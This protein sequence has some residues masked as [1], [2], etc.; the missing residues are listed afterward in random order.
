MTKKIRTQS[1]KK[2]IRK[3][4]YELFVCFSSF[5][6]RCLAI[7]SQICKESFKKVIVIHNRYG[8]DEVKENNE[9]LKKMFDSNCVEIGVDLKNPLEFADLFSQELAKGMGRT[10]Y[11]ALIDITTFNHEFLMICMHLLSIRRNI[12]DICCLYSSAEEYCPQSDLQEKWLSK[13]CKEIRPVLGYSGMLLPSQKNRLIIIVGYEY[14]R[15]LDVINM[16]E[17]NAITLIYGEAQKATTEK[18]KE[19]NKYYMSTVK[20]LSY[21]YSDE[22]IETLSIPC[23]DPDKAAIILEKLYEEYQDENVI[24]IPMNNKLSTLAVV[25]SLD[26][27]EDVQVCYAP[28][29]VYNELNY[30]TPGNTCYI[31]DFKKKRR[32]NVRTLK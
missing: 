31:Y 20:D 22:K 30:S 17:P 13:G 25:K 6:E 10:K 3:K 2:E 28:A 5:E 7:P 26:Q 15:A 14:E 16:L 9:S 23:N 8:C 11:N 18:N 32:K 19:A 27:N 4:E 1:L 21:G 24:V 12:S 29:H